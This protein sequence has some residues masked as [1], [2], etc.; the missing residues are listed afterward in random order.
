MDTI[1]EFKRVLKPGG[2]FFIS[3][4]GPSHD[5]KKK[6]LKTGENLYEIK[7]WDFRDGQNFYFFESK[8]EILATFGEGL[9]NV[10]VGEI[11]EEL[12][13]QTLGFYVV[14]GEKIDVIKQI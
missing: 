12:M 5:I 13:Q 10:E 4:V 9:S 7:D 1:L 11:T 6:A 14:S 3:T 2:R 8:T